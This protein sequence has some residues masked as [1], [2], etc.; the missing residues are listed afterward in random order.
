MKPHRYYYDAATDSIK[1]KYDGKTDKEV[2]E[3]EHA[4]AVALANELG[5]TPPPPLS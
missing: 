1:D 2:Q 5:T 3:I 4:A